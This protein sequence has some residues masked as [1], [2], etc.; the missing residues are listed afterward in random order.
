M[1]TL[2]GSKPA[3][4]ALQHVFLSVIYIEEAFISLNN[5]E[6]T[7]NMREFSIQVANSEHPKDREKEN[8]RAHNRAPNIGN[9]ELV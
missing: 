2:D 6:L 4:G 7:N 9:L 1:E 5:Q 8:Y 3:L